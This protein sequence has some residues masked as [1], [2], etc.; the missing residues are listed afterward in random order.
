M[1]S[2]N[3]FLCVMF[4]CLLCVLSVDASSRL[5]GN[6]TD[7]L[8]LLSIKAQITYD[9]SGV[10]NSWNDS[11]HHCSWQGVTCSARHQRVT[12]LDLSSK[13]VVGTL[14]PQI[15]NMSFLRELIL[16]NNTFNSQIP[17]EIGRLFR[18]KNLV[19]KDNSF[20]GDIPVELSNCSRLIYLDLDG[21]SL[22]GKIPVELSLSLRNLQVLFL[23]SNNLTG[24]LP[25]SLGNLSSLIALAAI[26]NRLEGSIPYSLGQ[27]TNLS[28]ISLGG[29]MLSG[30][31]P[32]SVF[33]LSSLYHLAAPVNQL[34]GTLPTDIG[35]TLP[36]LRIVF[37]FSNLL[38]GVLPSSISNL[39]NL[40][41]LS[42]SRNQLSGKIPSL[43]KLRNLQGLAMHFNNLG[44]GREDDMD[45]FS[46]LV[47][48][49][50]FK[51]LSLS[52]NNIAGQLP[53]N[54]GNLTNFRSIGFARNKLFGRIPDGFVD[55]SN[56]EVVSLE[57]NQLT[58][59]IPASLGKLQKL[60]YFYVNGN[61]LSGEIPSSIGNITSLY[62]LNLA[63][64]NL[65]GTI[66]SVLGNCQ[67]LQ[68]LYLSRNRLSGTIPKEVLS[69]SS[70]SIQLDLSGNQLSGSL[71]LE[72][73]SLVNL[74]YLD[75]SENKLSGKLPSTLSSCIKLENLYVQENMFEGVI[76]SSLSSLRGMEY[77]DLSRN[78]FSGLI[79]RYFETF[80]SLKS[81]NLSFNNFE[82]EVPREGV[83]SNASA[84]I[85]NG[86]RN[87]CG[88]SSALKLPQCNFPTSKK[89]RLMSST[90]KIAISIASALFGVALVL[91][92]LILCF[93]KRKRSPSLDLSDDSFLKISYGE[94]L[95]A[96]N[97][98]SSD[99]LIGKG[100][101]GS[102]YKGILGPDEKTVAIK[103]L[104]LQHKGALKSFIAEC[105]VLKNLRHR[106]LVKLVT[107]CSGTDF[108]GNDF[109]A[110]IY[111]FMVNGSLDDWLH[112]FSNDGSLHV[113][114]LDLYQ[115]VNIAS[116]IAFAL[117]YLHHG[118]QTPVVHCDL[119]PSNILLDKDMTARVGDFGLSRFLQETSQRETSTIGIKG[120]VGYAAPEYGMV[121]E[122]STYG[123]IY[124]YGIIILE[125]LTGKKPTDDA[126]SNGL[127]LHNYAKMAYSTGRVMEIVDQMVYHNLQEMKTKDYIEECSICMCKIGIACTID[128]PKERMRI[129][130]VIKELQLVKETLS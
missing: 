126:F 50:S 19:L 73:G 68:M 13:Q 32:L 101:F 27:L 72:V 55:L 62:G 36:S 94:L 52:V 63:Q 2:F 25:Y 87:L 97:G 37:L 122:V 110:L 127:N 43:E 91:V 65:E 24:E 118:T 44:T 58:E 59:E 117:D 6:E 78:N 108:Q 69:I 26:E 129:S 48:I 105:E 56:M 16:Q 35:S 15:G 103:A 128:S 111:E 64:N 104:D 12:M 18:L 42:L 14:V 47:N 70:L 66:P 75:I 49:T 109:K 102:V 38:S 93:L 80:I 107:A 76:P 46:S 29:N 130:D 123:D 88:G 112:S 125:M 92:L 71:P 84:A 61:K 23:R 119:K 96:T 116:D 89:G 45:F 5:A 54:I 34:K 79:P 120:S 82:G 98:F 83:F 95:K 67:L 7:R 11:F 51:E 113:R 60:K 17:R 57:Y 39:T 41:I 31:I 86:N 20:T 100:G 81:L 85:V 3:V 90:L 124:S 33:N 115:R 53:K 10:T 114:Y 28:Y 21:N 106:N 9:P 22:T 121:S 99:Y 4:S 30:S 40:E 1:K 74:G 77:L 8:A